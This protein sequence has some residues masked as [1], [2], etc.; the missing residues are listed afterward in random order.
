TAK[1]PQLLPPFTPRPSPSPLTRPSTPS[2]PLLASRKAPSALR[3]TQS[4]CLKPPHPRSR[5][6]AEPTPPHSPSPS[7]TPPPAQPSTTRPTV[8]RPPPL[9][10]FTPDRF[11]S[12]L[13]KR[14]TLS[15]SLPA[16]YRAPSVPLP[17]PSDLRPA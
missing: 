10:L 9:R 17:T 6:Q 16:S 4:I 2:P 14:S 3:L 5:P 12:P 13:H 8:L 11:P 15:P 7:A 1:R